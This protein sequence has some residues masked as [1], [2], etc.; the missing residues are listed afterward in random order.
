MV[1]AGSTA[2]ACA[3]VAV[4]SLATAHRPRRC[5][6]RLPVPGS[7]RGLGRV[8]LAAAVRQRIGLPADPWGERLL[9]RA[10]FVALVLVAID[11]LLAAASLA[12]A[13]ALPALRSRNRARRQSAA[14]VRELPAVTDLL[15]LALSSLGSVRLAV[16]AT[17]RSGEGPVSAAL[18]TAVERVDRGERLVVALE[19]ALGPLGPAVRPLSRALVGSERYGVPLAEVLDRLG[20]E[21]RRQRRRLAESDARRVPVRLLLPLGLCMLPG[22]VVLTIVPVIA[23]TLAAITDS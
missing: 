7:G 19:E 21:A 4:A 13:L 17:A 8:R 11:P 23:R 2:A 18:R 6:R 1:T 5:G 10:S 12:S 22:F 15:A 3:F 9:L 20:E 14:V 16:E